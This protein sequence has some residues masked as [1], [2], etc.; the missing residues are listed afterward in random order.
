MPGTLGDQDLTKTA[1]CWSPSILPPRN[2]IQLS[3]LFQIP[4]SNDEAVLHAIAQDAV[5]GFGIR[6]S[7]PRATLGKTSAQTSRIVKRLCNHGLIKKAANT[8]EYYLTSLGR[9]GV[10]TSLMLKELSII[11]NSRGDMRFA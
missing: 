8:H 10:A 2:Y 9:R 7:R 6:N 4:N 5:Q 1:G 11:P 3:P